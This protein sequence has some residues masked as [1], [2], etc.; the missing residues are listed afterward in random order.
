MR[1][2]P[3]LLRY[4]SLLSLTACACRPGQGPD[5]VPLQTAPAF[6]DIVP[7]AQGKNLRVTIKN[8]GSGFISRSITTRVILP[9]VP[10]IDLDIPGGSLGP[11]GTYEHLVPIPLAAFQPDLQFTLTADAFSVV[12][13]SDEANNTVSGVCV[14]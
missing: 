6:C 5:L 13:E 12:P 14:G 10:P 1:R 11:G 7:S 8:Q 2:V 4:S 9:G 3:R